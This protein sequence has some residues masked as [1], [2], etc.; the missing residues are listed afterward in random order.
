MEQYG[1]Q[2]NRFFVSSFNNILRLEER[3]LAT[4]AGGRLSVN[5]YHVIETVIA[6]AATGDN[7]MSEVAAMLG[8]TV[9]TLT[10]AV[11]TLAAKG[12]LERRRGEQDKRTV[13]LSATALAVEANDFHAEF[14]RRMVSGIIDC[15]EERQLLALASALEVLGGWF[16]DIVA[17]PQYIL[18]EEQEGEES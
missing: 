9:G 16:A 4:G 18:V 10:T 6:A 15:L 8:V 7:S 11:K 3:A 2:L 14:H 1:D 5:E 13:W 12:F 17:E